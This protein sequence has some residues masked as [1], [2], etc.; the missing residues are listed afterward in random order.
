MLPLAGPHSK[1]GVALEQLDAVKTF[2]DGVLEI[3][4]LQILIEIDKI[5]ASWMGKDGKRVVG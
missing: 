1:S 4:E 3:L 2:L 5:L